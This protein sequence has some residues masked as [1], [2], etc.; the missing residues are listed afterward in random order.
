M[1]QKIYRIIKAKLFGKYKY[2][3]E[4]WFKERK[5]ICD[6]CPL[7]SDN[8]ENKKGLRFVILKTLNL[9][10]PFCTVCG[11]EI[12]AK[13]SEQYESCPQGKWEQKLD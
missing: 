13:I 9:N 7:Q 6:S 10:K 5:K 1:I 4:E 12:E 11:C 2:K 3:N 8:K